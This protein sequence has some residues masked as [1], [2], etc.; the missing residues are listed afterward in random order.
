MRNNDPILKRFKA[1]RIG[2]AIGMCLILGCMFIIYIV[3]HS[4]HS[5]STLPTI[6]Y[7]IL[8]AV[9]FVYAY[10]FIVV[11]L[12][13]RP[14]KKVAQQRTIAMQGGIPG[15]IAAEQPNIPDRAWT[16]PITLAVHANRRYFAYLLTVLFLLL[17]FLS[18]FWTDFFT[19]SHTSTLL[20]TY[21]VI[22]LSLAAVLCIVFLLLARNVKQCIEITEEGI[23]GILFG[24]VTRL[25]WDE[26]QFFA[27]WGNN[28]KSVRT[29]EVASPNGVIRWTHPVLNAWYNSVVPTISF[30]EYDKQMQ[31]VL[32]IIAMKTHLPLYDL[33][34][35][36][37]KNV[38]K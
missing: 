32:A 7:T 35:K 37:R 28:V 10:F 19:T 36:R 38:Q 13:E 16:F 4:Q 5:R 31:I 33:R 12:T 6:Y 3:N 20:R 1:I 14:V 11:S 21:G 9:P 26:I 29:Y 15:G 24:Q 27:L 25:R 17:S 30:E 22:L 2:I 8:F 34:L 18:L 23:Q